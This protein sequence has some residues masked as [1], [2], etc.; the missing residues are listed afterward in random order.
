M[1][2]IRKR[3]GR[4]ISTKDKTSNS[5]STSKDKQK[6]AASNLNIFYVNLVLGVCAMLTCA[7]IHSTYMHTIHENQMFFTG[8]KE[9]EREISF[10]T[11]SGLYYSYYK[12]M[13]N[14]KSISSGIQSLIHDNL[15]EYPSTINILERMN[16]Y[17]EV[18]LA[19]MYRTL[20][21]RR[22]PIFFYID[23]VFNLH[24]CLVA[25]LFIMSWVL[26]GSWLAGTLTA[27]FYIL[28]HDETTRIAYVL[29]LRECFSLPFTWIQLAAMTFYLKNNLSGWKEKLCTA[30]IIMSTFL[31]ALFWQFNQ[32]IFLLQCISLF[33]VWILDMVHSQ[34][35]QRL[36][37]IILGSMLAVWVA[38]FGNTMIPVSLCLSFTLAT[39]LLMKIKGESSQPCSFAMRVIKVVLYSI[40][41]LLLMAISSTLLKF[42]LKVDSDDHIYKFLQSKFGFGELAVKRDFDS[43]LYLCLDIFDFLPV[44][45]YQHLTTGGIFPFYL[46]THVGLL[47]SLLI[48]IIQ[49]WS[50]KESKD[51]K[52]EHILSSRQDLA[53]HT[54]QCVMFGLLAITTMRMKYLW[55]PY[56]CVL[57]SYGITNT[58]V[59]TLVYSKLKL[60]EQVG[61]RVRHAAALVVIA[62][63][64]AIKLPN[65]FEQ[66]KDLREFWDPD[67][68]DLMEWINKDIPKTESFTGSMQ[69]LAGVKLCTG[70][71]I[72]NHPHYEDKYLRQKTKELYQIYGR[73]EPAEVHSILKKHKSN[74][75]I[76]EDSI[77]L[78]PP[79]GGCRLPDLIDVDNGVIPDYGEDQ[80]GLTRSTVPRF[81]DEIRHDGIQYTKYFKKVF[82]NKTFRVHRV[83]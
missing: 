15:T 72:T 67:T 77:C 32:F 62:V 5:Y 23:A 42:V 60:Q 61:Y 2:E 33:G 40:S 30:V 43:R 11:E 51:S 35:V 6:D 81:C 48:A 75:I 49:N 38:Q 46:L 1:S 82:E 53:F 71:P 68:V 36:L 3:K 78:A 4:S 65:I 64:L 83:L 47:V 52:S 17:Q 54:V 73:R 24:G 41:V 13:V 28:N 8:I 16:I 25:A 31:F 80:A 34:K 19:V 9:V 7:Y 10:R 39:L 58:Q 57:A 44:M 76:L 63:L 74:Y 50:K 66:L 56:M 12:Q 26:S 22:L 20:G 21:I 69:L 14:A 45:V 55:T 27:V 18:F 29:P 37:L 79:S 70:R 59:W